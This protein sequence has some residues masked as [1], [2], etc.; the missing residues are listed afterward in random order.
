[1][2]KKS[3]GCLMLFVKLS[4]DSFRDNILKADI[5]ESET[6]S[7]ITL[8]YG[9]VKPNL[10]DLNNYVQHLDFS[11]IKFTLRQLDLFENDDADILKFKVYSDFLN[12]INLDLKN[13]FEFESDFTLYSPHITVAY[14]KKGTGVKYAKALEYPIIAEP[15][16]IVYSDENKGRTSWLL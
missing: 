16:K 9:F 6:E 12:S 1:M 2:T 3:Y 11:N 7:H 14:L 13:K 8:L 4:D 10:S 5:I 15:Y